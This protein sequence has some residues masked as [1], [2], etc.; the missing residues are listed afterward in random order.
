M[1]SVPVVQ[2]LLENL[3]DEVAE[4]AK[5]STLPEEC[6]REF[7]DKLVMEIHEGIVV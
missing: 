7:W 3:V 4:L 2:P 1:V 6:D 5:N